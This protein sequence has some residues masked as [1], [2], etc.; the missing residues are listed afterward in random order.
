M[1]YA[2]EQQLVVLLTCD[3][4][5]NRVPCAVSPVELQCIGDW[6][7]LG[8]FLKLGAGLHNNK[9]PTVLHLVLDIIQQ[10]P[11]TTMY[12]MFQMPDQ[13]LIRSAEWRWLIRQVPF[14]VHF[15]LPEGK[16]IAS[17]KTLALS[18]LLNDGSG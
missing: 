1:Q 4:R 13:S 5:T 7:S 18:I 6:D 16:P 17:L 9:N 2:K 10:W 8:I 11:A 3:R 15:G 14:Q 12:G